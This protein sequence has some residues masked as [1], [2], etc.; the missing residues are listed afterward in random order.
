MNNKSFCLKRVPKSF[1][2]LYRNLFCS[3]E[4]VE[5][6]RK[7]SIGAVYIRQASPLSS[8]ANRD[9]GNAEKGSPL[10]VPTL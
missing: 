1:F 10:T 5:T 2:C 3:R 9:L 8:L 6:E 7:C 4:H